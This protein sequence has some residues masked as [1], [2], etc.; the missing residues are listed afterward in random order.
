MKHIEYLLVVCVVAAALAGC[1]T[2]KK[3]S[4]VSTESSVLE[5]GREVVEKTSDVIRDGVEAVNNAVYG[6]KK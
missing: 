4:K 5:A 3:E 6:E 1:S 2:P